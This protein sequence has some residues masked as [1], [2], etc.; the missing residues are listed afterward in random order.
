MNL[1]R[2]NPWNDMWTLRNRFNRFFDEAMIPAGNG[3]DSLS[4]ADWNPVVDIYDNED[5]VVINAELPGIEKDKITVDVKG[6][7][8]TLCGERSDEKEVRQDSYYRRERSFG[9]FERSFTLPAHVE[10]E[11]ITADYKDGILKIHV[12]K[13]EA[14]KPKQITVN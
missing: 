2:W 6:R 13:P 9:R 10:T 3:D 12:P 11:K 1:V 4:L 7:V 8:L 5:S 14:V